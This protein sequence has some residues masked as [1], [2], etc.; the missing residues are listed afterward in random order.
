[1]WDGKKPSSHGGNEAVYEEVKAGK[2]QHVAWAYVR[3]DGGRGFGF[4]GFHNYSNLTNDS[5]R[6][7]LL[8]AVAWTA[9]LEVPSGGIRTTPP[10]SAQESHANADDTLLSLALL[11]P[12]V[13][14]PRRRSV[15]QVP[16]V[17]Q[18]VPRIAAQ[19][20]QHPLADSEPLLPGPAVHQ[21]ARDRPRPA[22]PP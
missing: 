19:L 13:A 17:R 12:G 8:N 9:K 4:T 16:A 18:P 10:H 2:P 22:R 3:P 1:R 21:Q 6:T 11:R 20:G 15:Q 14:R 7:L 5:F